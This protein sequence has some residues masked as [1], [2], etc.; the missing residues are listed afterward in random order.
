MRLYKLLIGTS[1]LSSIMMACQFRIG[2]PVPLSIDA[3]SGYCV[4]T[5]LTVYTDRFLTLN[6]FRIWSEEMWFGFYHKIIFCH[7]HL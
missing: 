5:P 3:M 4:S 7:F 6:M 1:G 2:A